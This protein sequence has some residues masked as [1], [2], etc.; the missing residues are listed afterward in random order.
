MDLLLSWKEW[1]EL[2]GKSIRKDS[3][4]SL[5][6]E[7]SDKDIR[8]FWNIEPGDYYTMLGEYGLNGREDQFEV[9]TAEDDIKPERVV[10]DVTNEP[11]DR[12]GKKVCTVPGCNKK[13]VAKGFCGYHYTKFGK[14]KTENTPKEP[15]RTVVEPRTVVE[16]E[17][18]EV[19][20]SPAKTQEVVKEQER[21][22]ELPDPPFL[23]LL[24]KG[25]PSQLR[26]QFEGVALLLE[27][28]DEN[29]RFE[30]QLSAVK[31]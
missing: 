15:K 11:E 9:Q 8:D 13:H 19:V 17:F 2:P 1:K 26:K 29:S 22:K 3:L 5:R 14:P 20:Q 7:F 28:Q 31:S 18:T 10:I 25:N 30:I 27:G 4:N 23:S 21:P 6:R 12:R 24:L 16:A